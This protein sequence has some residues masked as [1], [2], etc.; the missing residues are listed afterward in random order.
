MKFLFWNLRGIDNPKSKLAWKDYA[1]V[2]K[3]EY[4]F[5]IALVIFIDTIDIV[6]SW[7]WKSFKIEN[8]AT[9]IDVDNNAK[10]L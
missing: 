5:V 1:D 6:P 9:H 7:Y 3:P 4:I 2:H 10:L 8:Y